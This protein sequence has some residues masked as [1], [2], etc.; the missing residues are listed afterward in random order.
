MNYKENNNLFSVVIFGRA[1]VGKSTLFNTLIEKK[2]ALV[3]DIPGTT[4]DS[5]LGVVDWQRQKFNLVDTGGILDLKYLTNK[6]INTK[7]NDIE[8]KVQSQAR[9]YLTQADLIL[10]LVDN[11]SGL[12]PQD[13][14]LALFLKKFIDLNKIILTANKVDNPTQHFK[15]SEFFKLGLGQPQTISAANGSG[16]GDLLDIIV[17]KINQQDKTKNTTIT[18]NTEE[19]EKKDQNKNIIKVCIIG[20]PNVGKSSLLNS[21]LGYE[22]VIVSPIPHTTREPQDTEINYQEECVKLI[23][24]AGISK[25]GSKTKGLEKYGIAKSL[26][27]LNKA[28][29]ALLVLDINKNITRQDARLIEE[30]LSRWKSLIIIANKWDLIKERDTKKYTEYIYTNLPFAQFVPIQ[31]TSAL[32]NEKVKKILDLILQISKERKLELSDSQLDKFLSRIV[33]IHRPSKGKGVKHPHIYEFKQIANNPPKFE[34]RIG[35]KEDLHFSYLR[36]IE[37]RLR[38][39]FGFSGTPISIKI[40]KGREIK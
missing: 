34:L 21:V 16:T 20:K 19:E 15:A 22:R 6:L 14:Q 10:F 24:T 37:N 5:N 32:T 31:F 17:N 39:N 33:K 3:A 18:K 36:F 25:K 40:N 4:R 29:I 23:D 12:M 26:I 1:N 11:K 38:E 27:A 30:I 13:K 35:L 8:E 7:T 9:Q 28:D 2:Q